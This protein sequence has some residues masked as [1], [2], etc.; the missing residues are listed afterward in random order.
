MNQKRSKADN[1]DI[2]ELYRNEEVRV[3]TIL[4]IVNEYLLRRSKYD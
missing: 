1:R 4:K 3:L 2:K